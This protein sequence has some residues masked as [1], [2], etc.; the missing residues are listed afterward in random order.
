MS[1]QKTTMTPN[2]SSSVEISVM[3]S[4]E[5]LSW[6]AHADAYAMSANGTGK[7]L[8]QIATDLCKKGY[9][10]TTVEVY[11]SLSKQDVNIS[12]EWTTLGTTTTVVPPPTTLLLDWDSRAD[13]ITLAAHQLGHSPLQLLAELRWAGYQASIENVGESMYRQ[14]IHRL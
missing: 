14:G 7:T 2:Q 6:D 8:P 10:A 1:G 11:E 12:M 3:K 9:A 4:P 5:K 13:A